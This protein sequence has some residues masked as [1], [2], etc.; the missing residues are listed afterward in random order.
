M[1]S[2]PTMA[3]KL[4]LQPVQAAAITLACACKWEYLMRQCALQTDRT[5]T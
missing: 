3:G 4:V 5:Y 2:H 1:T